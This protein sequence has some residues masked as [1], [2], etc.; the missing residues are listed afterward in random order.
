MSAL[1]FLFS[2]NFFLHN[3]KIL[4]CTDSFYKRCGFMVLG[5]LHLCW[6]SSSHYKPK[7]K[8]MRRQINAAEIFYF[9][10]LF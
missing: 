3:F 6:P 8:H 2:F 7:V 5:L 9:R 1:L 10:L 4:Y